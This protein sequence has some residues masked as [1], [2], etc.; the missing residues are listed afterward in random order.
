MILRWFVEEDIAN[1]A[2]QRNILI[3]EH[4]VEAQPECVPMKG[5]D[6]NVCVS[7]VKKYFTFMHGW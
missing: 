6:E 7:M 2:I 1:K 5:L 3:E 4:D